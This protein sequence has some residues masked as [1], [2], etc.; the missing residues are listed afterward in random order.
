MSL[1]NLFT[2]QLENIDF[3]NHFFFTLNS[4]NENNKTF[5]CFRMNFSGNLTKHIIC[6]NPWFIEVFENLSD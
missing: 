2:E 1:V 3:L 4:F 6:F 5:S